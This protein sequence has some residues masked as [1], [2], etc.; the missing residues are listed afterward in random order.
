MKKAV[1]RWRFLTSV[2]LVLLLSSPVGAKVLQR[3]GKGFLEEIEGNLVL[4]VEGT[5]YEMGYQHGVLLR[6]KVR[7]IV[8]I[9][10]Y[11]V[12]F[13][14][15][16]T[17]GTWG[18]NKM[19]SIY[20]R[21]EPHIPEKYKEEMKGLAEGAG[22]ELEMVQL[23]NIMPE[24]FHC[25]GF[26]LFGESSGDG[27]I[28]HGRILDYMVEV[29]FQ[30]RAVL[31]AARPSQGYAFVNVG[32]AGFI[33]SVSG[34]NEKR[35]AFGEIGGKGE[36]D[37]DGIP[38]SFLMR[39]G[40]EE[41]GTLKEAVS[42]FEEVP[43]TCE[44]YYVISD[45]KDH[46]AVGIWATP[47]KFET[48]SPGEAHERL[49]EPVPDALLLSADE[50]YRKLVERVKKNYGKIDVEK[51]VEIMKRPVAMRS[52]LHSCIFIPNRLEFWVANAQ[53]LEPACEQKFTRYSL[54]DLLGD[55]P[56]E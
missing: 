16:L 22:L 15:T 44:Y 4:H 7:D 10:V 45:G 48:I 40:L 36:G 17:S 12:G 37:W 34:M 20:R 56:A 35:I 28:Y 19:R 8:E 41:A 29:G 47:D 32:Y 5:P 39:R 24:L 1:A 55:T 26:V 2:L 11:G 3:E 51:M 50:R 54:Q 52:N 31:I 46:D 21:L 9:V 38:M 6:D 27:N 49:P 42:I 23:A 14:E 43:R 25:S 30:D 18:P 33:G 13:Y 53:G